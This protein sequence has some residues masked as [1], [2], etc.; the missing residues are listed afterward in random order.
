MITTRLPSTKQYRMPPATIPLL[1]AV[2]LVLGCALPVLCHPAAAATAS[3]S[4]SDSRYSLQYPEG[5]A[6][7]PNTSLKAWHK[8]TITSPNGTSLLSFYAGNTDLSGTL[9]D[10]VS[11]VLG[12]LGDVSGF[13]LQ[14]REKTTLDG[15]N[16]VKIVYTWETDNGRPQKTLAIISV[17]NRRLYDLYCTTSP[18]RYDTNEPFFN[19]ILSSVKLKAV[20]TNSAT[21]KKP[22]ATPALPMKSYSDSRF[23][24][25]YP[26]GWTIGPDDTMTSSYKVT[27]Y[28]PSN[29]SIVT[30][31]GGK[32]SITG[33]L[34]DQ[35]AELMDALGKLSG[36]TLVSRQKKTF[37]GKSGL[38]LVYTWDTAGGKSIKTMLALA[39]VDKRLY[40]IFFNTAPESYSQNEALFMKI[41]SS[42][43][44][45][46]VSKPTATPTPTM[47]SYSDSWFSLRHPSDWT[48]TVDDSGESYYRIS[49][50]SPA[51]SPALFLKGTK[52]ESDRT[53]DEVVSSLLEEL[54]TWS[55]YTL[56]RKEK[57]TLDGKTAERI[58][59]TWT[60]DDGN[61]VKTMIVVSVI[62]KR[63]YQVFCFG[64]PATYDG[65]EATFRQIISS[66]RVKA[67]S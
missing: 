54:G 4:Y 21:T 17:V 48:V 45:K 16:A 36:F 19:Q 11:S 62:N 10:H 23:S 53:L 57:T 30:L 24:L 31:Y 64:S 25:Q 22:T 9:D 6:V 50:D 43:R 39:I 40:Q 12:D 55:G 32:E 51:K 65:T 49:V 29:A 52:K 27:M 47:T 26:S 1:F 59:F 5:W 58:V 38:K 42:V 18:D 46:A 60:T 34:E 13:N 14:L 8:V 66:V 67:V 7:V 56:V 41:T 2:F 61:A 35:E 44:V 33:D 37:A 15:K 63:E 20:A 28:S 3:K